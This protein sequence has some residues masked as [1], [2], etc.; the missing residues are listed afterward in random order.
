MKEELK[1]LY[2]QYLMESSLI[3]MWG[4]KPVSTFEEW[5]KGFLKQKDK[6][7]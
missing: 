5:L 7:R 6:S 1:N 2:H 3:D 4:Q